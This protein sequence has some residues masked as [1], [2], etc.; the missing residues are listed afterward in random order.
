MKSAVALAL[1][2]FVVPAF[3]AKKPSPPKTVAPPSI[4]HGNAMFLASLCASGK[5]KITLKAQALG[6]RFF[7]EEPAGVTV[8][9]F[10][11][12]GYTKEKFFKGLTMDQAVKQY[13]K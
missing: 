4:A 10:D 12:T 3:A 13:R 11:G 5:T 8:Y 9:A 6:T 2:L 1:L 7:L